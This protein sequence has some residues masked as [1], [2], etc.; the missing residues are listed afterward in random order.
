LFN[1]LVLLLA[2]LAS[3]DE[4]LNGE[5]L[6]KPKPV[7]KG[8]VQRT[9]YL[10]FFPLLLKNVI[11][12]SVWNIKTFANYVTSGGWGWNQYMYLGIRILNNF[13][14]IYYNRSDPKV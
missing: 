8:T 10:S 2:S 1:L 14:L 3:T 5:A 13:T 4:V 6:G 9:F 7:A 11:H 12:R